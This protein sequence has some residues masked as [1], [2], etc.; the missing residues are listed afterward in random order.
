MIRLLMLTM[1]VQA[2]DTVNVKSVEDTVT[3][4]QVFDTVAVRQTGPVVVK[5]S[6]AVT[7]AQILTPFLLGLLALLGEWMRREQKTATE[8]SKAAAD[9]AEHA[10]T[11][12]KQ[13]STT[14]AALVEVVRTTEAARQEGIRAL[15]V[16]GG[17][18]HD[19]VDGNL[20]T[21]K[22]LAADLAKTDAALRRQLRALGI[23]PDVEDVPDVMSRPHSPPAKGGG[24]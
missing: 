12:A 15:L 14:A 8:A 10:A 23:E 4:K 2:Q 21:F 9:N 22:K 11:D 16:Q 17:K 7:I 13:A 3:V 19:L 20:E 1:L 24:A 5:Q 6:D 18:I